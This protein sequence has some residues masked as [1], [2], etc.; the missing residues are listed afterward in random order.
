MFVVGLTGGIGTGKT[1]VSEILASLGATIINADLVGHEAY[2][3]NTRTSTFLNV[4]QQA[5][6]AEALVLSQFV[7]G[8]GPHGEGS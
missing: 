5:R 6:P 2:L 4:E 8:A 7:I 1:Q 3:P